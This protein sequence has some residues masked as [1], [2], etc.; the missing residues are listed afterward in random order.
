[1]FDKLGQIKKAFYRRDDKKLHAP[2]LRSEI[3]TNELYSIT[4]TL[5]MLYVHIYNIKATT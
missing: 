5:Y 3:F 2:T 1:M 4:G